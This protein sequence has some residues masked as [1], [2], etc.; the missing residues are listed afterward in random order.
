MCREALGN[1]TLHPPPA[2]DE[3]S[4]RPRPHPCM[5]LLSS[6]PMSPGGSIRQLWPVQTGVQLCFA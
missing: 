6:E 1:G 2:Q 5:D 3:G 4:E